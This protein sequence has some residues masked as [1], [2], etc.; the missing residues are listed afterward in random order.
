M[1][2]VAPLVARFKLKL[3]NI[4]IADENPLGGLQQSVVKGISF[5]VDIA[6]FLLGGCTDLENITR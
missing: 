2:S 5:H 6:E 4:V 3:S 1:V